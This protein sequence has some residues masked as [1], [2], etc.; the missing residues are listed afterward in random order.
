MKKA[1]GYIRVSTSDQAD[2][3]LGLEAQRTKITLYCELHGYELVEIYA[4][5]GISGGALT[6]RDALTEALAA[7][8][9]GGV[10]FMIVAKLD[11]FTRSLRDMTNLVSDY[12]SD[13]AGLVSVSESF[14][15]K[16]AQGELMMNIL[17][18]FAQFERRMCSARTRDALAAKRARGESLGRPGFGYKKVKGKKAFVIDVEVWPRVLEIMSLARENLSLREIGRRVGVDHKLVSRVLEREAA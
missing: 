2:S 8:S 12:F 13:G 15:T 6:G 18:T 11:R 4:D 3:G 14:D 1:I 17:G 16:T 7:V 9:R 5:E 10:D